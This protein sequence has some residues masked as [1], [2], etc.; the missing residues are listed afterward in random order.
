MHAR[1][2]GLLA[3]L[4]TAGCGEDAVAGDPGDAGNTEIDAGSGMPDAGMPSTDSGVVRPDAGEPLPRYEGLPFSCWIL[5]NSFCNPANNAGCAADEACDIAIDEE[6][7]PIVACFPPPADQQLGEACDN[8]AGPWCAGGLRCSGGVCM[9]ACCEDSEC[10]APQR[11]VALDPSLGTFGVCAE[12]SGPMCFPPGSTC[13]Q[14]SDCCSN[15]CHID[16]CH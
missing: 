4:I 10:P 5:R 13:R 7:R 1:R 14:A 6:G 3:L 15:I 2:L 8:S 16:H 11:C 9:D 12:S